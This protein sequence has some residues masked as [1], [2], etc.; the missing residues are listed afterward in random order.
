MF[1]HFHKGDGMAPVMEAW[2]RRMEDMRKARGWTRQELADRAGLNLGQLNVAAR[3]SVANPRHPFMPK[4]AKA[5]ETT[6]EF[7]RFGIEKPNAELA[8]GVQLPP[9]RSEMP[10]DVP[11][12][13]QATGGP[14]GAIN[15]DGASE[16]I[17]R[18]GSL[19]SVREVYAVLVVGDSMEPRYVAGDP[20]F[21]SPTRPVRVGDDVVVQCRTKDGDLL[22]YVKVVAG[23]RG[24]GWVYRQYNPAGPWVPPGK[25]ETVHRI[26]TNADLFL[27]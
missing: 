11:V 1:S 6:E 23:R 13:G 27:I 20:V 7:L 19:A 10:Q 15:M 16:F 5:L 24:A 8:P 21:V 4:V 17:R 14:D 2:A 3:G 18:P 26:F 12:M 22:A 25:V 9:P